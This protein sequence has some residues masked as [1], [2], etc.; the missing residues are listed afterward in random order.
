MTPA[1]HDLNRD[2]A[3]LRRRGERLTPQRRMVLEI[4]QQSHGH[5]TADWVVQQAKERSG[6]VSL[7]SIY[8][9]LAWLTEHELMSVTDV[10][11]P[12][13]VYEYLGSGRH[14]HL[15]CQQCGH[16]TEVPFDLITPLTSTIREQYGFEARIDHQAIFGT[17]RQCRE[18]EETKE[19]GSTDAS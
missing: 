19:Q 15:I 10:G 12:D 16:E 6:N 4:M 2:E 18:K 17:C 1:N 5:V 3:A 13:L 8:R 7:A 11:S 14:H 9:I